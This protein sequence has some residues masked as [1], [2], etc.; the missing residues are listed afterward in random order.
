MEAYLYHGIQKVTGLPSN[1]DFFPC[2]YKEEEKKKKQY[3][4]IFKLRM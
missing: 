1:S 3:S 2:T 4:K